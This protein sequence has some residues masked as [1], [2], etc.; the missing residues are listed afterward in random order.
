MRYALVAVD[1]R[2]LGGTTFRICASFD[3]Q[4][5]QGAVEGVSQSF[6]R[7][8]FKALV[9]PDMSGARHIDYRISMY[10]PMAYVAK[11]SHKVWEQVYHVLDG[12]G[13]ID[14]DGRSYVVR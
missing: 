11:H 8:P 3:L 12:E 4:H 6:R 9:M 2:R 7:R 13:L 10:Q 14:I 5:H 1:H